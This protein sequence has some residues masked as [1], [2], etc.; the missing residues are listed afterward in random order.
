MFHHGAG[1]KGDHAHAVITAPA[2]L[3]ELDQRLLLPQ[4]ISGKRGASIRDDHYR[5]AT[6]PQQECRPSQG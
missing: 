2:S 4:G 1:G 6:A 3:Q 5:S